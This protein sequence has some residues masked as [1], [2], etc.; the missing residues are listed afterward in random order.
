MNDLSLQHGP[1]GTLFPSGGNRRS[2]ETYCLG[3]DRIA[4][5]A[6]RGFLAGIRVL[7]E[8]QV[9]ALLRDLEQWTEPGHPHQELW[10]EYRSNASADPD[11]VMLHASG[12][13]RLSVAFHDLLWH[14]AITI[15]ARQLLGSP[16][17][18][19]QDQ[20][21][22][23]ASAHGGCVSWHQ[24]YS[25]WTFSQPMGHLA[26]WIALDDATV[27]NGCLYYVPGS[28]RWGLLP[29]T[30][31]TGAMESIRSVL[32]PEQR[33]AFMPL[34]CRAETRKGRLP[35]PTDGAWLLREPVAAAAPG[36]GRQSHARRH[37]GGGRGT[38]NGWNA[39]FHDTPDRGYDLLPDRAAAERARAR[40]PLFSSGRMSAF[41]TM[42]CVP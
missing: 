17:R 14:P 1:I 13:W 34:A 8:D 41:A 10:Y 36:N 12:A 40:R 33:A 35:P 29:I 5:Y 11:R 21:F 42:V 6:E 37:A 24:D 39:G 31:L 19:L 16:V 2:L 9:Q 3:S 26:C 15:P 23:K 22:C 7:E 20:L 27:E 38:G 30:G 4:E 25:Y 18:F 32:T 28:H